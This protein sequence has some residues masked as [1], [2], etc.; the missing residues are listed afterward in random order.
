MAQHCT[1][2]NHE[3]DFD[4]VKVI[5]RCPQWSRKLFLE[6]W[7]SIRE[8]NSNNEHTHIPD[9]SLVGSRLLEMYLTYIWTP[10]LIFAEEGYSILTET[11]ILSVT[12]I[13]GFNISLTFVL[14]G[15][16]VPEYI[17]RSEDL[18]EMGPDH[19]LHNLVCQ[20][21]ENIPEKRPSAAEIIETL[22]KFSKAVEGTSSGSTPGYKVGTMP[23]IHY[24]REFKVV[25]M[26]GSG[27]GKTSIVARFLDANKK[28]SDIKRLHPTIVE[29]HFERLFFRSKS[30][31]LHL[32]DVGG[33]MI[34]NAAYLVPQIFRRV[35]GAVIVF[36]LTS[37]VS[38]L[39]L[40]T[41]LDVVK[42][43]RSEGL[44]IVLV[45]NKNDESEW[46]V[47]T[48]KVIDF[49]RK[50]GMFYI[51]ASAKSRENIDEIF[52]VLVDLMIERGKQKEP[53]PVASS[54]IDDSL[55]VSQQVSPIAERYLTPRRHALDPGVVHLE[56]KRL[57]KEKD[58]DNMAVPTGRQEDKVSIMPYIHHDHTFNTL[59]NV[60]S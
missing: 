19:P 38:F 40:R 4:D 31:H 14:D 3:F 44:P 52:S 37:E 36:D 33:N 56:E 60:D 26:G 29:N 9:Q 23:H 27:A 45:G 6:A 20:C 11:S 47:D 15:E 17:R 41:W 55:M 58:E 30:V 7:H 12:T 59:T 21:F 13:S 46:W 8:P 54:L 34:T 28:S 18:E 51:E 16:I 32:V 50:E 53:A 43:Q 57:S 24:D 10:F 39:A 48:R 2:N 42:E 1:Q 5:D 22:L 25:I 49:A 35:R